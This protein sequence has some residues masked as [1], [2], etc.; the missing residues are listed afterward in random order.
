MSGRILRSQITGWA[1]GFVRKNSTEPEFVRKNS[2]ELRM[3]SQESEFVR[4]NSEEPNDR[5][6]WKVS[7]ARVQRTRVQ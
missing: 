4:K 3:N 5:M 2:K 7:G 1:E 6:G